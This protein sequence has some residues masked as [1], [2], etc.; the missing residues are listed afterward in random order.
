MDSDVRSYFR[1]T[2]KG[3]LEK[4]INSLVGL[5]EGV[6]I[7]GKV[8]PGEV[9]ILRT[10]LSDHQDVANRHPFNELVPVL[11]A[12]IADG[13]LDPEEREDLLWLCQRLRST[14]YYD[15][16]TADLQRLHAL[17]GGIGADGVITAEEMNG[18]MTRSSP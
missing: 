14:E 7:D 18:L 12:A 2:G 15:K 9:Q 1:F 10:W 4:S 8:T 6:T 5:L 3:R 11:S 17:V 16:V 13:V